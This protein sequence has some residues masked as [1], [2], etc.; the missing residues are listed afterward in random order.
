MYKYYLVYML[1]ITYGVLFTRAYDKIVRAFL[2][3]TI[4]S[5]FLFFFASM[6]LAWKPTSKSRVER[7]VVK[8]HQSFNSYWLQFVLNLQ[9]NFFFFTIL[10]LKPKFVYNLRYLIV[11]K[12]YFKFFI[13]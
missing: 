7:E 3:V 2:L 12:L 9:L 6:S 10:N 5:E 13:V 8:H 11:Q 4:C 1:V